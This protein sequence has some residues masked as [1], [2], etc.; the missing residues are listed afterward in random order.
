MKVQTRNSSVTC[1]DDCA[2]LEVQ[3]EGTTLGSAS[4]IDLVGDG[5]TASKSGG[6]VTVTIP[7]GGAGFEIIDYTGFEAGGGTFPAAIEDQPYRLVFSDPDAPIDVDGVQY[8]HN[9]IIIYHGSGNWISW[10][11]NFGASS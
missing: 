8:T 7:G 1:A 9:T 10:S 5:V 11:A 6:K 4:I 3:D 2:T